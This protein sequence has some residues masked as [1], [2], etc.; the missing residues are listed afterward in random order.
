MFFDCAPERFSRGFTGLGPSLMSNL[1]SAA[2]SS[3]PVEFVEFNSLADT[4]QI[5]K[6]ELDD[7]KS[8]AVLNR[9]VFLRSSSDN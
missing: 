9:P 1:S 3:N 5:L 7:K 6:G 2:L 8:T 4:F